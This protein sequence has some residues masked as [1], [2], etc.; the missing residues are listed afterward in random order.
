MTEEPA[1]NYELMRDERRD[2]RTP[3]R[4]PGATAVPCLLTGL[5]LVAVATAVVGVRRLPTAVG[6]TA[7]VTALEDVP[8]A[9][10]ASAEQRPIVM[11]HGIGDSSTNPGFASLCESAR[12]FTGAYVVCAPV[13]NGWDSVTMSMRDQVQAL[14]KLVKSDPKLAGGFHLIG[15]SQGA[16]TVRGYVERHN[17]PPVRRLVSMVG[18]QAGV[19]ACPLTAYPWLCQMWLLSP[20]SAP[21]AF[22]GYW[23]D[24]D[25][26]QNYLKASPFLAD[27]N[28]ERDA[29]NS[30]YAARMRS[31]ELLVAVRALN[32][33]TVV[34]NDSEHFGFW[35]WNGAN[36]PAVPLRQTDGYRADAIG[37][38]TLDESGRLRLLSYEG[39][40]MR[41]S[42]A[43]WQSTILPILKD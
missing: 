12:Q 40:H 16:L 11:V 6:Q 37:L 41:F 24:V 29:T 1:T 27:I 42:D 26:E 19:G 9:I 17:R 31:L 13:A 38:R 15:F 22:A 32:D 18:P 10:S 5:T 23:K 20:Y 21:V 39:E 8:V 7:L 28:N 34:P 14:A 30:S 25:D 2:E 43:Y 4:R 35:A 36:A 3:S 33:T